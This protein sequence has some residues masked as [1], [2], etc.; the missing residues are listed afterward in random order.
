MER[1]VDEE[2]V[3]SRL[4]AAGG[5][6][7]PRLLRPVAAGSTLSLFHSFTSSSCLRALCAP[8]SVNSVLPSL[9]SA[10]SASSVPSAL[11]LFLLF[12]ES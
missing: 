4:P 5:S 2:R 3:T 10:N 1:D 8:I 12:P 7:L 11:I 6:G 9:F